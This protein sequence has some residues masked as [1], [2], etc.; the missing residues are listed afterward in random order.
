MYET[1][2]LDFKKAKPEDLD[3][4][5]WHKL[6]NTDSN[7]IKSGDLNSAKKLAKKYNKNIGSILSAIDKQEEIPTPMILKKPDGSYTLVGGNTRLMAL[8]AKGIKPKVLI[9]DY[10]N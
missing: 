3:D 8:R 5:I 9:V 10:S 7:S 4:R 2:I 6:E 1:M